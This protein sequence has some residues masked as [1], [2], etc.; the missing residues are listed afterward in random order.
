MKTR[1]ALAVPIDQLKNIPYDPDAP[2]K[3]GAIVY[4]INSE[5]GNTYKDGTKGITIGAVKNS[6][7]SYT[8][9]VEF[10]V[11]HKLEYTGADQCVGVYAQID[12]SYI[13]EKK[14]NT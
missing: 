1:N 10:K 7:G 14:P 5:P 2:I 9:T 6:K 11:V 4:K 8:Y 13:T 3:K 12:A